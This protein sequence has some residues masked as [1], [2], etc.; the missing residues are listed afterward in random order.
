M[1][2]P[3]P[4]GRLSALVA[5]LSQGVFETSA[6]RLHVYIDD[7]IAVLRGSRV[8]VRR[9]KAKLILTWRALKLDLAFRKGQQGSKIVWVG[10]TVSC[11]VSAKTVSAQIKPEFLEELEKE[12]KTVLSNSTMPYKKLA[13]IPW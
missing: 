11:D 9:M 5:R 8:T 7:P 3:Q 6:L 13:I 2:G 1:S 12:T 4:F 10:H